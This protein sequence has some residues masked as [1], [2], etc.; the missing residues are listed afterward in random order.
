MAPP[1]AARAV[2]GASVEDKRPV[3]LRLGAAGQ[4][5]LLFG[6]RAGESGAGSRERQTIR[7]SGRVAALA[8]DHFAGIFATAA[9]PVGEGSGAVVT[10]WKFSHNGTA[11]P[12][13]DF[14]E[15]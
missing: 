1:V 9:V 6:A 5:E 15:P 11:A 10:L 4:L 14:L 8:V 7:T 13:A 2:A 12:L 3:Y